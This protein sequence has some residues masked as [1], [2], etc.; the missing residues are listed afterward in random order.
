MRD[1]DRGEGFVVV[2]SVVVVVVVVEV[3]VLVVVVGRTGC[4]RRVVTVPLPRSLPPLPRRQ[5]GTTH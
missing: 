1:K 5:C 3:V 2:I 4:T